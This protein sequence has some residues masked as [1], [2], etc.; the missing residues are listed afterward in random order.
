[1]P[2]HVLQRY[3]IQ[4]N[5]V[6]MVYPSPLSQDDPPAPSSL[7]DPYRQ[8]SGPPSPPAHTPANRPRRETKETQTR[9]RSSRLIDEEPRARAPILS[10]KVELHRVL[11]SIVERHFRETTSING[12]EEVDMLAAFM[13]AVEKA[14]GGKS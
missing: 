7:A 5:I 12:R 8:P 2:M 3:L 1:M 10:D 4:F 11:A 9:R 14:K 6:P 13:C